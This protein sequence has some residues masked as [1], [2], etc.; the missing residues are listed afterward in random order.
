MRSLIHKSGLV[1]AWPSWLW[2]S[3]WP[4]RRREGETSGPCHPCSTCSARRSLPPTSGSSL[5]CCQPRNSR[6][7]RV[8]SSRQPPW[9]CCRR[10]CRCTAGWPSSRGTGWWSG[11]WDGTRGPDCWGSPASNLAA[12]QPPGWILGV[13][14]CQICRL[15][16]FLRREPTRRRTPWNRFHSGF[17]DHQ[18]L[19]FFLLHNYLRPKSVGHT[20]QRDSF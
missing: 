3:A 9:P 1:Q 17:R 7:G 4:A 18:Q 15:S 10:C 11:S 12:G 2:S 14:V 6:P 16:G 19:S 5:T 13:S 8:S 20:H